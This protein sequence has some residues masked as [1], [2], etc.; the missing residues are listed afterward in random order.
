MKANCLLGFVL[1]FFT[2]CNNSN[3]NS[4]TV[5]P[6]SIQSNEDQ[7]NDAHQDLSGCYMR[8]IKRDTLALTL[9]QNGNT[10]NGKLSFDN[11]EKDGSTGSVNGTIDKNILK[12][13]YDFQSEGMHSVM[14]VYFKITDKGL[15]HGIG[16]V[17][18]KSDTTYYANPQ[19]INYPAEN[20]L[21]K[22]SCDQLEAKFK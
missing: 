3:N 11:Y 14:E 4:V 18:T 21:L 6:G 5:D 2:A 12:L 9:K 15:I 17:A 8:T 1:I 13:I 20:E 7:I 10:V 19:N 16:D 22:I